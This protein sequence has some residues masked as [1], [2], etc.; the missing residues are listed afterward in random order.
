MK[1]LKASILLLAMLLAACE[2]IKSPTEPGPV[3]EELQQ[4]WPLDGQHEPDEYE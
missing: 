1:T 2:G 3:E 4:E